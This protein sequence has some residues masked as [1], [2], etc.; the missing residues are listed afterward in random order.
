MAFLHLNLKGEYFDQIENELKPEEYRLYNDFWK[1][2][3]IGRDYEGILV[4]KGYPKK[5]DTKRIL[6][7]PWKGFIIKTITHPHFGNKPEKVFA[8]RVND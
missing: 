6:E 7:R 8:I 3:L 1:K 2:R 5:T 4:K